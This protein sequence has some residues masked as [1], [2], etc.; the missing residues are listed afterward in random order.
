MIGLSL[1]PG[2]VLAT[3][4]PPPP[5]PP[6]SG[7]DAPA[8]LFPDAQV[9][10]TS[11]AHVDPRGNWTT[12]GGVL[13]QVDGNG[14]VDDVRLAFPAPL[15]AGRAHVAV[16]THA[17][18]TAGRYKPQMG[19]SGTHQGHTRNADDNVPQLHYTPAA[20]A[21]AFTR[22]G[23]NPL[24]D[25]M[26]AAL[27][28][29]QV[30]DLGDTDP[31]QAACDVVLCLGDSN[32]GNAVSDFVTAD[33]LETAFDPRIWYMP[34]L[35][36][37]G[38]FGPTDSLRHV[39]QPCLEPVQ[40]S[41]GAK[42]MSPVQACAGE[43]VTWSAAR[44]RPLMMLALGDP[45]SGLNGAAEWDKTSAEPVTG[46]LMYQEMLAML[47]AMQGLGPAHR[48]IGAVASLGANDGTAADYAVVWEPKAAA[49]VGNL[50]ADLGLPALPVV[51]MTP[52]THY[53]PVP[54]EA[55]GA[56]MI[57]AIERL[58]QNSGSLVAIPGLRAVRPPDGNALSG[59]ADPHFNG[60][61]MQA[62]GRAMGQ[63]LRALL[64]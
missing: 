59:P 12:G 62:N 16:W 56:R 55:R 9:A 26:D 44:G 31:G 25:V 10:L 18:G 22:F 46:G 50:R 49:F 37:G 11:T 5:P 64:G 60:H 54:G 13:R 3:G 1:S 17:P 61:G 36:L 63:A 39:P 58:D 42:R 53:D 21:T 41:G 7:L 28:A 29:V 47:T 48:I 51:W 14:S 8:G 43:L 32:M 2:A 52:G 40:G 45:G 34:C 27:S 30:H 20:A 57:A 38:S 15:T 24:D 35:R 4:T 19:G 23:F 33:T 6:P